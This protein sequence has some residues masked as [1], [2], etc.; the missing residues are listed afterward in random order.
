MA[1]KPGIPGARF[2][3][4]QVRYHLPDVVETIAAALPGPF[5]NSIT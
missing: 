4:D 3:N 1:G 5:Q 2:T